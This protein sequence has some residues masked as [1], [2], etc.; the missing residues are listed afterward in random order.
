MFDIFFLLAVNGMYLM[1]ANYIYQANKTHLLAWITLFTAVVNIVLN[2][3]LIR[4][5]G[6]IGAAQA[7]AASFFV[8]FVLTWIL[9]A[10]VCRMPWRVWNVAVLEEFRA[11]SRT[12]DA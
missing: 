5:N 8:G 9:S 3:V 12:A 1:V 7:S 11:A 2:Y 4:A 6:A 10:R